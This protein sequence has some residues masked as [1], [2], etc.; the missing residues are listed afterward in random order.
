M[1]RELGTITEETKKILGDVDFGVSL[2]PQA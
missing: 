2:K 1:I